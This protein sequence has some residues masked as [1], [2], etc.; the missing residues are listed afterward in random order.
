MSSTGAELCQPLTSNLDVIEPLAATFSPDVSPVM[1]DEKNANTAGA[2]AEA[3]TPDPTKAADDYKTTA[4]TAS[5][6]T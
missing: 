5:D 2:S 3:T 4:I 1:M 6:F